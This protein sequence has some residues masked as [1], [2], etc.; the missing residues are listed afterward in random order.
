MPEGALTCTHWTEPTRFHPSL[1][2]SVPSLSDCINFCDDANR[3]R[4][5]QQAR[6]DSAKA[7]AKAERSE[8][9]EVGL[10]AVGTGGRV[11]ASPRRETAKRHCGAVW[12]Q[13]CPAPA[14]CERNSEAARNPAAKNLS[15]D[16]GVVR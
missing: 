1:G 3:L 9:V 4:S 8:V 16:S 11:L 13:C 2:S 10:G 6:D 15:P 5:C 12:V 7:V 14:L